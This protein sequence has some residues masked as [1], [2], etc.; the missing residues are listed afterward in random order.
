MI[1]IPEQEFLFVHNPYDAIGLDEFAIFISLGIGR[2]R[3]HEES[4]LVGIPGHL[5]AVLIKSYNRE[6]FF[7]KSFGR[8][9]HRSGK[10]HVQNRIAIDH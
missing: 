9:L 10:L 5:V 1:L 4:R 7:F 6:L 8:I 3:H 2:K